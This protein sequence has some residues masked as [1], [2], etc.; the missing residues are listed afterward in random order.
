MTA[1][2]QPYF[3]SSG[4]VGQVQYNIMSV[5]VICEKVN[6]PDNFL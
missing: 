5:L 2:V 4:P 6:L 1:V 3:L